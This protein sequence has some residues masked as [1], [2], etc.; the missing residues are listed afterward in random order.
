[1]EQ[2]WWERRRRKTRVTNGESIPWITSRAVGER[3]TVELEAWRIGELVELIA[4]SG[5]RSDQSP[6]QALSQRQ[7]QLV[8]YG[9]DAATRS[10]IF[11]RWCCSMDNRARLCLTAAFLCG[12]LLTLGFKDFYPDLERRFRRR[13]APADSIAGAG[14]EIDD[15][16]DLEDHTKKSGAN[17]GRDVEIAEGIEAC[18][19]D[20][21]LFRIKSLSEATGCDILAKAE[22]EAPVFAMRYL[23]QMCLMLI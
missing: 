13:R 6:R 10:E 4:K 23:N 17:K 7:V 8:F 21:A 2:V 11:E 9:I 16:I 1:M 12:V 14:L 15:Q 20:T 5:N 19:G 3:D 22:V 18:V